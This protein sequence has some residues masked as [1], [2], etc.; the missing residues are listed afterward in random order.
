MVVSNETRLPHAGVVISVASAH[1]T[2]TLP[3]GFES[4]MMGAHHHPPRGPPLL[5]IVNTAGTTSNPIATPSLV[6]VP[7]S[8]L[9]IP[10]SPVLTLKVFT[11]MCLLINLEFLIEN[12][13]VEAGIPY[14]H[15]TQG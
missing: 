8:C 14:H 11:G 4:R 1:G 13:E 2:G 6:L 15:L 10:I 3:V 5:L 12:F 7:P 9:N